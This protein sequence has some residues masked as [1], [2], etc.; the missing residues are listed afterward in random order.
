MLDEQGA[1][2]YSGGSEIKP[3]TDFRRHAP[4]SVANSMSSHK[5]EYMAAHGPCPANG[6]SPC[7]RRFCALLQ[8]GWE[9][10]DRTV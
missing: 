8:K 10:Y 7:T 5:A 4:Y 1:V 3:G 2:C 9:P 6:L